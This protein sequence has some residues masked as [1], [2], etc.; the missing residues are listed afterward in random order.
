VLVR[1]YDRRQGYPAS[2][3][4]PATYR[5]SQ[6]AGHVDF[7]EPCHR[8]VLQL[9]VR[10]RGQRSSTPSTR[11]PPDQLLRP[12]QR[13]TPEGRWTRCGPHEPHGPT[14]C[15]DRRTRRAGATPRLTSKNVSS[16]VLGVKGSWVQ[17]PPSRPAF[18]QVRSTFCRS[19]ERQQVISDRHL[20][21][22]FIG[23]GRH[24]RF[25]SPHLVERQPGISGI[26]LNRSMEAAAQASSV[27]LNDR[28]L[29]HL[30]RV[31]LGLVGRALAASA[32]TRTPATRA[33]ASEL[34][35]LTAD[36]VGTARVAG[37]CSRLGMAMFRFRD[38]GLTQSTSAPMNISE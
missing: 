33:R 23:T 35:T 7:Y 27:R 36:S 22:G 1:V 26:R 13:L 5:V 9:L 28:A 24:P 12:V 19:S 34:V 21:V 15:A 6:T 11:C 30:P 32:G 20:T 17:I 3:A 31:P 4:G 25:K 38:A 8:A 14:I 18:S 29:D 2:F 37:C 16:N 10:A